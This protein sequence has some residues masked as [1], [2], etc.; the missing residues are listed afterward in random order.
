ALRLTL[1]PY[2]TLF[3]SGAAVLAV[4]EAAGLVRADLFV[5]PAVAQRRLELLEHLRR[6]LPRAVA[7]FGVRRPFVETDEHVLAERRRHQLRSEEHT[8]E[9]QS[10]R[11]L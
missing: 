4:V 1:F 8:S 10:L 5:E 2:T 11:H 9:L 3:R 7:L 6:P